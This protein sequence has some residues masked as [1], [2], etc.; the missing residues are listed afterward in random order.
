MADDGNSAN[1][2]KEIQNKPTINTLRDFIAWEMRRRDMN[3]A[4]FAKFVG[5]SHELVSKLLRGEAG[6]YP[7]IE[8]LMKLSDATGESVNSL[9][10]LVIPEHKR[11]DISPEILIY[12]SRI[13]QLPP[14]LIQIL[15]ALLLVTETRRSNAQKKVNHN[16]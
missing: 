1:W 13:A 16:E 14:D 12:A 6:K 3:M 9:F 10:N 4:E 8:T 5:I 2:L 15:D 7:S 11:G